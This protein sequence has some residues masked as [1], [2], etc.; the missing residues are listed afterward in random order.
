MTVK[1]SVLSVLFSLVIG[2]LGA[3]VQGSPSALMRGLVGAFIALFR[4]TPPLVQLY[5]FYFAIGTVL[6]YTGET[7][8][9]SRW[10]RASAGRSS[11]CLCSQA[12]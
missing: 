2:A 3:W 6:R 9:R 11:R 7:G 12:R 5:F 8:C 4:N 1:L 10:S